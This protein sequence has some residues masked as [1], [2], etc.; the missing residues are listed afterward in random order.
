MSKNLSANEKIEVLETEYELPRDD[1][2]KEVIAVSNLAEGIFEEGHEKGRNKE[3]KTTIEN[4]LIGG[5]TADNIVKI[6]HY[7]PEEVKAVEEELQTV[8]AK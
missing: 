6:F 2:G 1:V 5:M 7:S 4:A 3:R 8:S